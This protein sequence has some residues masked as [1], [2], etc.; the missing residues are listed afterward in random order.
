M[1]IKNDSW[2]NPEQ[3]LS[4]LEN[5]GINTNFNF[6]AMSSRYKSNNTTNYAP[7]KVQKP[8][9][10]HNDLNDWNFC[11]PE[12]YN[13][14]LPQPYRLINNI[15]ETEILKPVYKKIFQIED[16]KNNPSYEGGIKKTGPSGVFDMG[17]ITSIC[18]DTNSSNQLLVGDTKGTV[19]LIDLAKKNLTGR[20][21]TNQ[22]V[23]GKDVPLP[24]IEINSTELHYGD[25]SATVFSA[26]QKG[27]NLIKIFMYSTGN[28]QMFH[29]CTIMLPNQEHLVKIEALVEDSDI[30]KTAMNCSFSRNAQHIIVTLL[31]GDVIVYAL[32]PLPVLNDNF[33]N[34]DYASA[35]D[36]NHNQNSYLSPEYF[37]VETVKPPPPKNDF[38]D[39]IFC[40]VM[41]D[42]TVKE[43]KNFMMYIPG[44][45]PLKEFEI[46]KLKE[47]FSQP[48]KIEED[49]VI[50]PKAA[51]A[52]KGGAKGKAPPPKGGKP[53][54]K[55]LLVEKSEEIVDEYHKNEPILFGAKGEEIT[56]LPTYYPIIHLLDES[57]I[58]NPGT[59]FD[60]DK[61]DAYY[62]KSENAGK[63]EDVKERIHKAFDRSKKISITTRMI[64]CWKNNIIFES[65]ELQKPTL[66]NLP[67]QYNKNFIFFSNYVH[68]KT[69]K[70]YDADVELKSTMPASDYKQ[71]ERLLFYPITCTAASSKNIFLAIGCTDGTIILWDLELSTIKNTLDRH[72]KEVSCLCFYEQWMLCSGGLDG[73]VHLY[74]ISSIKSD[75]DW[76]LFMDKKNFF[77]IN[78]KEKVLE[79]SNEVRS[80]CVSE[81][82]LLLVVDKHNFAR[83]YS[84]Y[85]GNKVYKLLSTLT[86]A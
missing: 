4:N 79:E 73:S 77:T 18:K 62:S 39:E 56:N 40:R 72:L 22:K 19:S 58:L 7:K 8:K 11:N 23:D 54:D 61:Y 65:Y 44:K 28:Y 67:V 69:Y 64:I 60:Y 2:V 75:L 32:P 20:M 31:N 46:D 52:Q 14:K 17:R 34:I 43:V 74:D 3:T 6:A 9:P 59:Y 86:F 33:S 5:S 35:K 42:I 85:H 76:S 81:T 84:V 27:S 48:I 38:I 51:Q 30:S 26:V 78:S 24:V 12:I 71:F 36:P 29:I 16:M 55:D 63:D 83:I 50:D 1:S 13:D 15:L 66:V 21:E 25:Y 80:I 47:K 45:F 68:K 82:G 10:K 41:S 57:M 37:G 70:Q 49:E 53:N